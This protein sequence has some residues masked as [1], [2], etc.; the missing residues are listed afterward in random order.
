M[1]REKMNDKV[2]KVTFGRTTPSKN[3]WEILQLLQQHSLQ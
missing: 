2:G 1:K 3:I